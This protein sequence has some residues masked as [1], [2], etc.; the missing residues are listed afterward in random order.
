MASQIA[1]GRPVAAGEVGEISLKRP[2]PVMFM[3]Y[4]NDED[5]TRAKFNGDWLL[6]GDLARKDEDGYLWYVGR[7]DDVISSGA[8][9]IGPGEIEACLVGHPAVAQAVAVGSPDPIRG[10][11]VKA[12]VQ[13]HLDRKPTEELARELQDHVRTRLSAHEYPREIEFIDAI[14]VTTTGKVMRGPLRKL[15]R[16]RKA[17]LPS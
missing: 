5:A 2:H 11:V 3:R 8:Y 6:T 1:A 4:W 9:R 7:K 16:E 15:E 12:F 14:P 17:G 13:L 10:E